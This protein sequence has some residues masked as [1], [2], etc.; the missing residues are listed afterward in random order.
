MALSFANT[1]GNLFNRIG[2][3][4]RLARLANVYQGD[5]ATYINQL[6]AQYDSSVA[7]PLQIATEGVATMRDSVQESARQ[8]LMGQLSGNAGT[9]VLEMVKADK[10]A[11]GGSLT[12]AW[13]EVYA[14]MV[15]AAATIK[16]CTV[17]GSA[18][19]T[20][21]NNGDGVCVVSVKRGDGR[22]QELLIPEVAYVRLTSD[23]QSGGATL[24]QESF[25][26]VGEIAD[27][28]VWSK[29]YPT[30]SGSAVSLQ[31]L[32]ATV[33]G[34]ST[35]RF[36]NILVNGAFE[37]FTANL[38]DN[39]VSVV[40]VAGTNY[41]KSTAT[42]YSGTA[43]LQF[44]GSAANTCLSQELNGTGTGSDVTLYPTRSYA[45]NLFAKVDVA[46]AAGVLTVELVDSAGTVINDDQGVANSF[47]VN[48]VTLGTSFVAKNGVFR[49][50]KYLP[51]A[52]KIRLRLSTAL[53]AGSNLFVDH[54][55]SGLATQVYKGGPGL[56]MFSGVVPFVYPDSFVL[57]TTNDYGGASNLSTFHWLLDQLF[58]FRN[59][60]I[61]L[62]TS[63]GPT[64]S[65]ALITA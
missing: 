58:G 51:S 60:D 43:S 28:S 45:V 40:G 34:V 19:A 47:T 20:T 15:T 8:D 65:D 16:K 42:K 25:T 33:D 63:A 13:A 35:S 18:A 22:D 54:M 56:T 61:L 5:L 24:G 49:M 14:Q 32:D 17:T 9:T 31:C 3:F 1:A 39:W 26:Y 6:L 23:A 44:I 64:I 30:G 27:R 57:T 62:P 4:G 55:A 38:P 36:G 50:P 52:V 2:R 10:P 7:S 53:S 41:Q 12:D 46:P 29:D 48:L 59:L 37:A 21:G 11:S